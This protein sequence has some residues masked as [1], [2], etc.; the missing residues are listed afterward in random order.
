MLK[1]FI[2]AA[3]FVLDALHGVL[4][5][6]FLGFV[7][8]LLAAYLGAKWPAI[9]GAGAAGLA[10]GAA[11]AR[12]VWFA[13]PT[14]V[15]EPTPAEWR[16]P[17]VQDEFERLQARQRVL[18]CLLISAW[19]LLIALHF[20][21]QRNWPIPFDVSRERLLG[22]ALLVIAIVLPLGLANWRCPNCR[23]NLGRTLSLRQ[24]PHCG[25][26]LRD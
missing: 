16:R 24:C 18:A 9:I 13:N 5:A 22:W 25:V 1:R 20:A 11:I 23:R 14:P 26:V 15:P 19:L 3:A 6:V 8:V 12:R 21:T 17:G 10:I 7:A 2:R 4:F